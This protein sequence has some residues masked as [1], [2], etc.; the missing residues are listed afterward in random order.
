MR[1]SWT[2]PPTSSA[3]PADEV[4]A[5]LVRLALAVRALRHVAGPTRAVAELSA[6]VQ[7]LVCEAQDL[8]PEERRQAAKYLRAGMHLRS[9]LVVPVLV[10]GGQEQ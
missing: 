1:G 9:A 6:L 5:E 2:T 4:D 7:S 3:Q 10:A 8:P